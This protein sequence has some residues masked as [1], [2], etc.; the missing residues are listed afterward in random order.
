MDFF[1]P[2]AVIAHVDMLNQVNVYAVNYQMYEELDMRIEI[3]IFQ[4]SMF[5]IQFQETIRFNAVS[6]NLFLI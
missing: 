3:Q 2:M 1:D 4:W 6:L 5:D